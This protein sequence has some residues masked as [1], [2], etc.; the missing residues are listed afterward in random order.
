MCY[1]STYENF[2]GYCNTVKTAIQLL[3][4]DINID[5]N[6]CTVCVLNIYSNKIYRCINNMIYVLFIYDSGGGGGLVAQSCLTPVTPRVVACQA[7]LSMRFSR[8]EYW[9]GL[10]IPSPIYDSTG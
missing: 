9:S 2:F 1:E 7:I 5:M 8:Q 4:I 10:P 3:L 6:A